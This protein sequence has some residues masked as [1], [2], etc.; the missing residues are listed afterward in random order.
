[1]AAG[2]RGEVVSVTVSAKL[3]AWVKVVP[4]HPSKIDS[5]RVPSHVYDHIKIQS[6]PIVASAV[7]MHSNSCTVTPASII[8]IIITIPITIRV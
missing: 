4:G 7:L 8:I 5:H 2:K 3:L 6:F 1:M